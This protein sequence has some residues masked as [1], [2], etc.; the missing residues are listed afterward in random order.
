MSKPRTVRFPEGFDGMVDEYL[1][2]NGLKFNQFIKLAVEKFMSEPNA[3]ELVPVDKKKFREHMKKAF[4][5]HRKA[6]D[7]LAQKD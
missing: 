4:S 1:T 7:E 3:I 2:Q 5:E 6:M